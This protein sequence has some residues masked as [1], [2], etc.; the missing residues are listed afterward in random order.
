MA[1]LPESGAAVAEDGVAASAE[2]LPVGG[3]ERRASRAPVLRRR[4]D[5]ILALT[6]SD[7]RARY[8]RGPL[9]MVKWL[10]DPFAVCGVYLLL[11]T[12]VLDRGGPAPG[13]SIA[14]AV[15][16]FQL[17]MNSVVGALAAVGLRRSIIL[18]MSF[19][20]AV[21]PVST[22]MTETVAFTASL[23]LLVLMMVVYGITPTVALLWFPLV[24]VVT[25]ILAV[26]CAY[27]LSLLGLWFRELRVFFVSFMR[28][29]FYLAPGLIALTEIEGRPYDLV[30]INPL[31]GIFESFRDVLLYGQRPAAWQLLVP[32]GFAVVLLLVFVP[33]YRVE[34]RDFAKVVE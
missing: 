1:A 32:L 17:L 11:V 16:P 25:I 10:L 18:N 22:V 12:F 26:A 4:A 27:P 6:E 23:L 20:R 15:V 9:R 34:Q 3:A 13:L 19:E 21:I 28:T 2:P 29:M 33:V 30:K 14:C 24:L 8:G 31:T 7:L 5:V